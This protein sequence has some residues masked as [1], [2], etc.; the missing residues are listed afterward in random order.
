MEIT[1]ELFVLEIPLDQS[2]SV[3][4]IW[5]DDI[6]KKSYFLSK[7]KYPV[8]NNRNEQKCWISVSFF[9]SHMV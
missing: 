8:I 2:E 4:E 7:L 9:C 6:L 1:R 3:G 5:S